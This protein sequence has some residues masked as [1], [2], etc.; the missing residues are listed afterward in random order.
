[1]WVYRYRIVT[2]R[3]AYNPTRLSIGGLLKALS[4]HPRNLGIILDTWLSFRKHGEIVAK[5]ASAS[6]AMAL[7]RLMP[8]ISGPCQ[9][10]RRLL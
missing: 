5:T 9:L 4:K 3:W 8:N 1:M 10:K 6:S 2:K 7:T